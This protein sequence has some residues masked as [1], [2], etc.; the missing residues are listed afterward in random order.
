MITKE[1]AIEIVEKFDFF[2]GQRAGRE[3]WA[4]KPRALQD[5]DVKN[6]ARDCALLKEFLMEVKTW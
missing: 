1:Q 3:L 2:Y 6:F 5:R 4:A